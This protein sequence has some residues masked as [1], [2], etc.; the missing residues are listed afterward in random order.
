MTVPRYSTPRG[1]QSRRAR[2]TA[3][4]GGGSF[5]MRAYV[6]MG[7][8][9]RA[10]LISPTFQ[11]LVTFGKG[12]KSHLTKWGK[13]GIIGDTEKRS[14]WSENAEKLG[15]RRASWDRTF[16]RESSE[17]TATLFG[18]IKRIRNSVIFRSTVL[19]FST[20]KSLKKPLGDLKP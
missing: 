8:R 11:A 7:V 12:E 17:I 2:P 19:T 6:R 15:E 20:S 16:V 5:F 14:L 9:G 3:I 10:Y 4:R 1:S 18:Y 13:S